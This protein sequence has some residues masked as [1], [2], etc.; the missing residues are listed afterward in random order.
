MEQ[1]EI[2]Y[3]FSGRPTGHHSFVSPAILLSQ[4]CAIDALGIPSMT[5]SD[6]VIDSADPD[7]QRRSKFNAAA[8]S[9]RGAPAAIV[10]I[11]RN[12]C[13]GTLANTVCRSITFHTDSKQA[14]SHVNSP[15]FDSRI[16]RPVR[17]HHARRLRIR[18][19]SRLLSLPTSD[20]WAAQAPLVGGAP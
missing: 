14:H 5:R 7:P 8:T 4:R 2:A 20:A 15:E 1:I 10:V 11:G 16:V 12:D 13:C 6:G 3:P 18:I 9:G 19:P 17:R